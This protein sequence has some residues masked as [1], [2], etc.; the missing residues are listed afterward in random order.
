MRYRVVV[1]RTNACQ[2]WAT[3]GIS[4]SEGPALEVAQRLNRECLFVPAMGSEGRVRWSA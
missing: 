2:A 1:N 3:R 4:G